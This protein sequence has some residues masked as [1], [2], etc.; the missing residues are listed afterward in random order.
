M[1]GNTRFESNSLSVSTLATIQKQC[2]PAVFKMTIA[3]HISVANQLLIFVAAAVALFWITQ[4][5]DYGQAS[6]L[7][8]VR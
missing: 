2:A 5:Q 7:W 1:T 3:M 8:T 6:A 4:V